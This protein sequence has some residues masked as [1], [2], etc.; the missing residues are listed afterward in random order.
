[1]N[2]LHIFEGVGDHVKYTE[3][4]HKKAGVNNTASINAMAR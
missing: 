2:Q 3:A 4:L 1:M